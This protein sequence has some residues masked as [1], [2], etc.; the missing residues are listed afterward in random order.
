[1][2]STTMKRRSWTCKTERGV[3]VRVRGR[4]KDRNDI[5]ILECQK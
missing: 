3:Y 5:I 4:W 1:M 2:C